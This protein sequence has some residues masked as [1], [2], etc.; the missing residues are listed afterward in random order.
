MHEPVLPSI[1]RSF[2]ALIL[3][4]LHALGQPLLVADAGPDA[5][6]CAGGSVVLGADPSAAGGIPPYAYNWSPPIGL[7]DPSLAN[8]DCSAAVTVT[9]TLM[10]TDATGSMATDQV[11]VTVLPST[12]A[13]IGVVEPAFQSEYNGYP[14]I[15]QCSPDVS[16][17][18]T[19]FNSG[20]VLAG[21]SF[22]VDWGDGS[23]VYTTGQPDWTTQHI[24]A[25]GIHTLTYTVAPPDGCP[26][27][28]TYQVFLGTPPGGGFSTDPNTSIC[29][30]DVLSLYLSNTASNTDGTLYIVDPGDGGPNLQFPHPPPAQIDHTYLTNSCPDGSFTAYF[31]AVNPC[32]QSLGQI[33][34]I[35][36]SETPVATFTTTPDDTVCVDEPVTFSD[37]SLGREAPVCGPPVHVWRV[38]PPTVLLFS[39]SLGS[40]NGQPDD[41]ESWT[42]GSADIVLYFLQPGSYSITDRVGSICGQDSTSTTIVVDCITGIPGSAD[43]G[44]PLLLDRSSGSWVLQRSDMAPGELLVT[45]M[46]G[47]TVLR[48]RVGQEHRIAIDL[49][50]QAPGGYAVTLRTGKAC[51]TIRLMKP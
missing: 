8:P 41:H 28:T 50:G 48:Q 44:T 32:G 37:Q 36:V 38:D 47:R 24:Y 5:T 43:G 13:E 16:A 6:L 31:T 35:R 45:D 12:T 27:S 2:A 22:T 14:T 9:Y 3:L 23:P 29:Q 7:N 42:S 30:G 49:D 10:V 17:L 18:F 33:S 39:G 46:A 51:R 4:P 20:T 15:T 21:S 34:P 26:A 1:L 25:S 11:T 19:F 40:I